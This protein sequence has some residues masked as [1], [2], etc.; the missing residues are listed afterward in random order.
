M[1]ELLAKLNMIN[2]D[3]K[4]RQQKMLRI[5]TD[6]SHASIASIIFPLNFLKQLQSIESSLGERQKLPFKAN[7][8][9]ILN[10]YTI[11]KLEIQ[12]ADKHLIIS[13]V[14]PLVLPNVFEAYNIT[15]VPRHVKNNIFTV[16]PI[17]R[18]IIAIHNVSMIQLTKENI[19]HCARVQN[20]F[21]CQPTQPTIFMRRRK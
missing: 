15:P 12:I 20:R 18:Q 11:T 5:L 13:L 21:I 1:D 2:T 3:I 7:E 6:P 17:L 16:T 19:E 10:F 8:D 9:N 14:I 4:N